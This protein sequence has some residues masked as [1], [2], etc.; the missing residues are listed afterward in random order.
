MNWGYGLIALFVSAL[1]FEFHG[2]TVVQHEWNID[3]AK[4]GQLANAAIEQRQA[5]N[6]TLSAK[7]T[8][9]NNTIQK[10][11]NEEIRTITGALARSERLRIGTNFC[12]G[13]ARQ[14]DT[15][16]AARSDASNTTSRVLSAE[17]DRAVKQLMMEIEQAAATGRAAQAFIRDN[18][19]AE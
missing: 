14:T 16:S 2:R 17:M 3:K 6:A 9:I 18:G 5:E 1:V 13:T 15:E 4:Q 10:E 7:Q 8:T 19:L 11:H 12:S